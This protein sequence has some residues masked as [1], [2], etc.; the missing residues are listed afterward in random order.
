VTDRSVARRELSRHR[1]S[2]RLKTLNP[3]SS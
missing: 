3:F 1:W 2:A